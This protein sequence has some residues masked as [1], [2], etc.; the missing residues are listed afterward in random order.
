[1][2]EYLYSAGGVNPTFSSRHRSFIPETIIVQDHGTMDL[3]VLTS[4]VG[5][6]PLAIRSDSSSAQYELAQV[7]AAYDLE[8][9]TIRASQLAAP[10][11]REGDVNVIIV[12]DLHTVPRNTQV[13][14]IELIRLRAKRDAIF[15]LI[16]LLPLDIDGPPFLT[17]HLVGE[18]GDKKEIDEDI[19]QSIKPQPKA[20]RLTLF[21]R[22]T[23][24][25]SSSTPMIPR[26][27][28]TTPPSNQ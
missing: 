19:R 26:M 5:Q 7:C 6:Q 18:L 22:R 28:G 4:V 12:E 21:R 16:A 14:A 9:Q 24:L 27:R 13:D 10:E 17:P 25:Y 15:L 3:A 11:I 1:M 2:T 23:I 20:R 8:C